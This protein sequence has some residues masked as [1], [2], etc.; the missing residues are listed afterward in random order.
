[1]VPFECDWC[2]FWKLTKRLPNMQNYQDK[3]LMCCIRRAVLDSFWSRSTKTVNQNRLL[4]K[5]QVTLSRTLGL[6]S[7]FIQKTCMPNYD[8]CGYELATSMLLMS[9]SSGG[10]HSSNN[11]QFD[12]V[13]RLRTAYGNFLRASSEACHLNLSVVDQD[14]TYTRLSQDPCGTL[15][16]HRFAEGMANRMGKIY[17][18][19]MAMSHKLIVKFFQTLESQIEASKNSQAQHDLIIFCA[20][21]TI[22]YVL[23]LRGDEGFLLDVKELRANWT[24]HSSK[25]LVIALL[26]K[27][28]G[29]KD[30]SIHKFPCVKR[31]DSGIN[32]KRAILRALNLKAQNG[33]LDGP[34]ISDIS[35]ML[36]APKVIDDMIHDTLSKIFR[37]SRNLFPPSIKCEDD[38]ITHYKSYR[39]F[40]RTSDTRALDM[41]LSSNDIDIVNRWRTNERKQQGKRVAVQMR[42]HY[43]DFDKLVK[44]FLRY[45]RAM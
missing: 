23:S 9:I 5:R 24:N 35:G 21:S 31:T 3:L 33:F 25:Y 41:K 22:S 26:G 19:N 28:K 38:I 37:E 30:D 8:H 18:P 44:P 34:L 1:M 45:T 14:S 40:R 17:I 32:V 16:F 27:L 4:V 42:H 29:E 11:L 2:I 36:M 12:T 7:P 15:W 39:T 43:S 10:K 20:Y 13:R 6:K